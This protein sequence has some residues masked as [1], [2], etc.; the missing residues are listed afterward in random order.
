MKIAIL[1]LETLPDMDMVQFLPEPE[2]GKTLKDPLKIEE[3]IKKKKEKQI[4]EMGLNPFTN[5]ICCA[6]ICIYEPQK[7][8]AATYG[9]ILKDESI[10]ERQALLKNV[11]EVLA[12]MDHFVTFNGRSF[13]IRVLYIQN[14]RLNVRPSVKIDSGKYNKGNH[15]DMRLALNGGDP[16]AKG[17]LNFF[18]QMFLGEQKTEGIDGKMVNDYWQMGAYDKIKEYCMDDCRLTYRLFEMAL[19]AGLVNI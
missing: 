11:W 3:D 1:D 8:A 15:T 7:E 6:G 18:A 10:Q 16:F 2:P 5:I 4:D 19:K 9:T 13:D 12:D 17:N 14:M